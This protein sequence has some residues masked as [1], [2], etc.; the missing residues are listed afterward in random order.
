MLLQLLDCLFLI[1][2]LYDQLGLLDLELGDLLSIARVICL[3]FLPVFI[4]LFVSIVG[5]FNVGRHIGEAVIL[6]FQSELILGEAVDFLLQALDM[7]LHLLFTSDVISAFGFEL[8]E[9]LF[10]LSVSRWDRR[11]TL[12]IFNPTLRHFR[13]RWRSNHL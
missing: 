4:K 5:L 3:R 9:E 7:K 2:Q 8:S 13:L 1:L 12:G 10:V 6:F 11:L